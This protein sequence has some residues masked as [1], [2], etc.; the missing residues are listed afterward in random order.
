VGFDDGNRNV[1]PFLLPAM[2]GFQHGVGL[3]HARSV[4]EKNFYFPAGFLTILFL[5]AG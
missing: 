3:P 4:T 1:Y 5:D 2:G